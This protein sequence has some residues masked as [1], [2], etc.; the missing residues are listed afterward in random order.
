MAFF[1]RAWQASFLIRYLVSTV[2]VRLEIKG[3]KNLSST[4]PFNSFSSKR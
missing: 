3:F 2:L 1:R 4:V